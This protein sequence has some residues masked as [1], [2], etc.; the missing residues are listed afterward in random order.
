MDVYKTIVLSSSLGG[1]DKDVTN[2]AQS[3]PCDY[4]NFTDE[5]FP[6]RHCSMTPRLQA[7]IPKCFGWQLKP[8]YDF[9]LWLDGNLSLAHPDALRY[10]LDSCNNYDVVVLKHPTHDTIHWEYRYNWRGLHNNAPSNYLRE[11]YLNE[12]LDEQY[13]FIKND[14]D[15]KDDSMVNGG[16]FLYRNTPEVQKTLKEWFYHITRYCIMDQ[17]SW[18]YVL[19]KS[20]LRVNILPD[21][22]NDCKWLEANR[23]RIHA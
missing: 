16:V 8:D 10:F 20:G 19:K 17:L 3:I 21:V 18:I 5:N 12:W 2:V 13:N 1:F 4:C 6:P 9:Y 15:Y 22:F 14:K 11:R 23:H 7:K